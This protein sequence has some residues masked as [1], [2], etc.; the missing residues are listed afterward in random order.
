[1]AVLV[2]AIHAVP[3]C[4]LSAWAPDPARGDGRDKPGHHARE[5]CA[6]WI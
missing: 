6:D 1:M 2:A 4:L 5:R 3:R